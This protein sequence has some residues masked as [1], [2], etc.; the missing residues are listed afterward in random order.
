[1]LTRVGEYD[2]EQ[3]DTSD[4]NDTQFELNPIRQIEDLTDITQLQ[5]FLERT[6]QN[7]IILEKRILEQKTIQDNALKDANKLAT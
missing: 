6:E 3:S 2:N 1:M 7:K 4:L 5:Y